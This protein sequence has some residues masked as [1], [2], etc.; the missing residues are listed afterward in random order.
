MTPPKKENP[1]KSNKKAKKPAKTVRAK[2]EKSGGDALED[3]PKKPL[4]IEEKKAL[5]RQKR[6]KRYSII[7][8]VFA[9]FFLIWLVTKPFKGGPTFGVCKTFLELY[10]EYPQEL[11]LSKVEDF[12]AELRIWYTSL[13][14]YGEYNLDYMQ[15]FFRAD[16]KT[17]FALEKV[18]VN[19]RDVD[20]EIVDRFNPSIPAILAYPPD[21]TYPRALGDD[22]ESLRLD[23]NLYRKRLF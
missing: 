14:P 6:F 7:V 9:F 16:E 10:V 21:L 22:L 8:G 19:R 11:M 18:M 13:D 17:G 5:A 3:A 1:A 23:P 20:Q 12:G 15:C 4:T 2:P